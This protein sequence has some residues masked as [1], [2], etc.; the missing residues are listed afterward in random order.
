MVS[1]VIIS[2]IEYAR[3]VVYN[4]PGY[5]LSKAKRIFKGKYWS[6]FERYYNELKQPM[7]AY[8][9]ALKSIT[10]ATTL[11]AIE[12]AAVRFMIMTENGIKYGDELYNKNLIR[13]ERAALK[14]NSTDEDKQRWIN[15]LYY[16]GTNMWKMIHNQIVTLGQIN[17]RFVRPELRKV[18]DAFK[19]YLNV[20]QNVYSLYVSEGLRLNAAYLYDMTSEQLPSPSGKT[21]KYWSR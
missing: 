2:T 14:P 21:V 6:L 12:L 5:T 10:D 13:Y 9:N 4:V 17:P 16:T 18:M 1:R 15:Y 11:N 7:D 8:T 3:K 19:V 20:S